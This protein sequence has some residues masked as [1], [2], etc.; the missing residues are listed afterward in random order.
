MNNPF[1]NGKL[2]Q[3]NKFSSIY[4]QTIMSQNGNTL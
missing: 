1:D 2:N 3:L 4:S